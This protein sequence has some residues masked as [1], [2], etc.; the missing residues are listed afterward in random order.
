[1]SRII[2]ITIYYMLLLVLAACSSAQTSPTEETNLPTPASVFCEENSGVLE[3]RQDT[4]GNQSGVCIFKDGSECEEWAFYRGECAPGE[5]KTTPTAPAAESTAAREGSPEV[6]SDGCSIY[7]NETLG[8]SFH[9]PAGSTIVQNDEPAK[10]Y[11]ITGPVVNGE[12]WPMFTISHPA[13]RTEYRPPEGVDL[14]QWLSEHYLVG[15][16]RQPDLT[17]A[18]V[19][20]IHYRHERSPQSYA[21][22]RYYFAYQ[23]QL[24]M[25]LIGHSGD[26]EDWELCD[27]FMESFQFGPA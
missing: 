2:R 12:T 26:H 3:I 15:E 17:I 8:Y 24:Y 27:H 5:A 20:A 1:M 19:P 22:D 25:I 6:V 9:Y 10:S 23:G 16:N 18:G 13:D 4:D 14:E 7:R 21:D 11:T